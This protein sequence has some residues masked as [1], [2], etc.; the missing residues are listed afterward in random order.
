[1]FSHESMYR[2]TLF[3]IGILLPWLFSQYKIKGF[4]WKHKVVC[5]NSDIDSCCSSWCPTTVTCVLWPIVR[6]K[7]RKILVRED[8][9]LTRYYWLVPWYPCLFHTDYHHICLFLFLIKISKD[10]FYPVTYSRVLCIT[11]V[12]VCVC[13]NNVFKH[14]VKFCKLIIVNLII[15]ATLWTL[16]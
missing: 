15:S 4:I 6:R 16:V 8:W 13:E 10:I 12:C 11:P 2:F 1:M 5:R 3:S 7:K 9:H 14:S